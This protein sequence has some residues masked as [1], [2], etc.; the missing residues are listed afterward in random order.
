MLLHTHKPKISTQSHFT[1][2]QLHKYWGKTSGKTH[3]EHRC[4]K[5]GATT[6]RYIFIL[7][8]TRPYTDKENTKLKSPLSFCQMVLVSSFSIRCLCLSLSFCKIFCCCC[9]LHAFYT[10]TRTHGYSTSAPNTLP[11]YFFFVCVYPHKYSVFSTSYVFYFSLFC[12][13]SVFFFYIY[14]YWAKNSL[15]VARRRQTDRTFALLIDS[16]CCC[17]LCASLKLFNCQH[18]DRMCAELTKRKLG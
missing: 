17:V 1:Y 14:K 3:I 15:A 11:V 5:G 9:Y 13:S 2:T 16:V 10:N 7:T 4:S 6:V 12:F 8:D 18:S